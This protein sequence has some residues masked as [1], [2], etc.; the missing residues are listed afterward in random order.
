MNER[1]LLLFD[2]DGVLIHPRGY[3]EALRA[4]VDY[5]AAQ[6][7]QPP[8]RLTYDEIALF[9]ACGIT[10]E[11]DS[12]PMCVSAMLVAALAQRSDLAR[13]TF[14]ETLDA[15]RKSGIRIVRPDFGTLAREVATRTPAGSAPTATIHRIMR[16]R[17]SEETHPLLAELFD[18]IYDLA[19]PT[20]HIFQHFTLGSERFTQ[21]YGLPPVLDVESCLLRYDEPLIEQGTAARLLARVEHDG[22]GMVIFTARPSLP[23]ADLPA[24]AEPINWRSHPPE[25]DLAA[26]LLGMAGRVPLIAGGRMTWLAHRHGREPG[27]YIKPSPVQA[28][29]ALGAACCGGET[30]ALEAAVAFVERGE[31]NGPLVELAGLPVRAVVFEDSVTGIHAVRRA[32]DLLEE[33]G[34]DVT[35]EIVGVAPEESKRASLRRVADRVVSDV[36]QALEPYLGTG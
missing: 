29:A 13:E 15:I 1:T 25:G 18:D 23:P 28:I 2:V 26:E 7:G 9:E 20:T 12:L 24:G 22:A 16:E 4:A 8:A 17:A 31:V 35:L 30:A 21:T 10:N 33:A 32:V 14:S 36:N 6:M 11:W 5:F 34:L 19:T 3:K 27:A